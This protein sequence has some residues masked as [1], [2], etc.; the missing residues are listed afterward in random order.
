MIPSPSSSCSVSLWTEEYTREYNRKY[1][2]ANRDKAREYARNY[3]RSNKEKLCARARELWPANKEKHATRKKAW[4]AKQDPERLRKLNMEKVKRH[5]SKP[6]KRE[7]LNATARKYKEANKEI[8]A[9]QR[10]EQQVEPAC[11]TYV[12]HLMGYK[13]T[14]NIPNELITIKREHIKLRRALKNL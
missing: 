5:R 10:K 9:K 6:E 7:S 1:R 14:D 2:Q 4:I 3:Y 13:A 8:L 11:D 12:K